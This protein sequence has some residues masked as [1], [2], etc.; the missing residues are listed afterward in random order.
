M[1]KAEELLDY[2]RKKNEKDVIEYLDTHIEPYIMQAAKTGERFVTIQ[3]AHC[4]S[5]K[6]YVVEYLK[7]LGYDVDVRVMKMDAAYKETWL[8]IGW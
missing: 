8:T 6:N 2:C 7:T 4:F 3:M 1:V 5:L